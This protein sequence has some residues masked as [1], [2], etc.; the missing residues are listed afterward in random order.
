M[1]PS[2]LHPGE[3]DEAVTKFEDFAGQDLIAEQ[4]TRAGRRA[5]EAR[6]AERRRTWRRRGLGM[7]ASVLAVGAIAG[8][9]VG[10]RAA[11][12]H[13][14]RSLQA[15]A[16]Y[17]TQLA[18]AESVIHEAEQSGETFSEIQH[19]YPQQVALVAQDENPNNP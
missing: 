9:Y 5:V 12:Q 11:D 19:E 16:D 1:K 14:D 13:V 10:V 17:Q 6:Q 2:E 7:A 15:Q 3:F 4:T 18:G 8:G